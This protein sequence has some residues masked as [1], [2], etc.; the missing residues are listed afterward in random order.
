MNHA[1]ADKLASNRDANVLAGKA[2]FQ[3]KKHN[4]FIN[5]I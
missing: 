5:Y 3:I 4:S 2:F 1:K